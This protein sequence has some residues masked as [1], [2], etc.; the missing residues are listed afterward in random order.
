MVGKLTDVEIY[1]LAYDVLM[2][3]ND[4]FN[5]IYYSK[6]GGQVRL[7]WRESEEINASATSYNN[8]GEPPDHV[9]TINY[10]LI[11]QIYI[12]S[13]NYVEYLKSGTDSEVFEYLWKNNNHLN[14]LLEYATEG[15]IIKYIFIAAITW[16]YFHELGHLTQ[17]HSLIRG[18][19]IGHAVNDITEYYVNQSGEFNDEKSLIW[20]VTELAADYFA[21]TQCV[22]DIIKQ[23][24]IDNFEVAIRIITSG[25]A[26]VLHRFNGNN[27]YEIETFPT[28]SHPK[29]F[30]RLELLIPIIF[31]RLSMTDT[32]EREHFVKAAGMASTTVSI[33]WLRRYTEYRKIPEHY[34][35]AGILNRPGILNYLKPIIEKWNGILPTILDKN[36]LGIEIQIMRF[37]DQLI[38]IVFSD[39]GNEL[40]R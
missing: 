26:I 16:V 35:I 14:Q 31:E 29:P 39:Q 27:G 10:G 4:I 37:S 40:V 17:E 25:I 19:V 21:T 7:N 38:E 13:N 6:L 22:I 9:I 34:M 5:E 3:N 32:I 8:V 15:A 36:Q 30:V 24:S 18:N 28:G 12:D 2:A 1:G 20:H 23:F 11:K 33:F